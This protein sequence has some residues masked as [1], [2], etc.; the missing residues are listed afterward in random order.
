V[1]LNPLLRKAPKRYSRT[2][3]RSKL[4]KLNEEQLK[5]RVEIE[6]NK[7]LNFCQ[8]LLESYSEKWSGDEK[9]DQRMFDTLN[10]KW[11][12]KCEEIHQFN[13]YIRPDYRL[14]ERSIRSS[15]SEGIAIEQYIQEI[16]VKLMSIA[17]V[18]SEEGDAGV[19]VE[20]IKEIVFPKETTSELPTVNDLEACKIRNLCYS[21]N[22]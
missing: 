17:K 7:Y 11:K 18:L 9:K 2:I 3:K 19:A 10:K 13:K 5:Q 8:R 1:L 15:T 6:T 4:K 12:I 14:F 20:K 16:E 21:K 22:L